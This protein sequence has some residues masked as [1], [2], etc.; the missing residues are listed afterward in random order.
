VNGLSLQAVR[1]CVI[2]QPWS[3]KFSPTASY[4]HLVTRASRYLGGVSFF[5]GAP[6]GYFSW[7]E[8]FLT[9]R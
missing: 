3:K 7:S 6:P 8:A 9:I 1:L 4:G 5:L 2:I